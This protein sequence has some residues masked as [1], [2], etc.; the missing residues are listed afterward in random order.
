MVS[1]NKG[2]DN[3]ST[4]EIVTSMLD[5][6]N[7]EQLNGLM[8]LIRSFLQPNAETVAAMEEAEQML[9]DP[10]TKKYSSVEELFE[11]LEADDEI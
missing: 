11:D 9:K 1:Y 2:A 10:N 3:M 5:V 6:L 4:K 8:V 7:E